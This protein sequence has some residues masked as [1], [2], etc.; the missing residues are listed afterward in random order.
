M[1]YEFK[2]EMEDGEVFIDTADARDVRRWEA[3]FKASFIEKGVSITTMTQLA[4]LA[5]RRH[6]LIDSRYPTWEAFDDM[7]VALTSAKAADAEADGE[8]IDGQ[9]VVDPTRPEVT[10][11]SSAS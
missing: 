6:K 1:K 8:T 3:T 11:A 4:Y 5:L 9:L 10:G 7:C 2:V